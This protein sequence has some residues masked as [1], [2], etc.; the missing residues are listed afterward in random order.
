MRHGSAFA[1]ALTMCA[2]SAAARPALAQRSGRTAVSMVVGGGSVFSITQPGFD[3]N[4]GSA[5]FAGLEFAR[6]GHPGSTGGLALRVE[7]GFAQQP[8]SSTGGVSGN[9][10]TVHAAALMTWTAPTHA[11]L[12]PFLLAG[13]VWA[14]PS[15]R[16]TVNAAGDPTP[17]AQFAETTH[18]TAF[19]GQLGIG[20]A[21]RVRAATMRLD[22]RWTM[23]ATA[24][25]TTSTLP[26]GIS[27]AFPMH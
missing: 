27:I 1:V 20:T 14:R 23:L 6:S 5:F 13:P 9:V 19:G 11:S 12:R 7:G 26:I 2:A 21:W 17:G 24:A 16:I 4:T 25:K 10:Q 18:A 22:V 8:L 15:T 3:R